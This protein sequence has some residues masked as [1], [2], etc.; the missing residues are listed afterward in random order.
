MRASKTQAVHLQ[1][2]TWKNVTVLALVLGCSGA[3]PAMVPK[4]QAEKTLHELKKKPPNAQKEPA[5]CGAH[6]LKGSKTSIS[7]SPRANED[8]ERLAV[9]L[10]GELTAPDKAYD[11]IV[12]DLGA[13]RAV[14][15]EPG[16]RGTFPYFATNGVILGLA[17]ETVKEVEAGTYKGL[18]CLNDWYGG[19]VRSTM[20]S[21]DM[22]F[23]VFDALYHPKV[24]ADAYASH[25]EVRLADANRMGGGGDDISLCNATLGGTHRYM[26]TRAWGDCP[27]GCINFEFKGYDVTPAGQVTPLETWQRNTS[28]GEYE[29]ADWVTPGCFKKRWSAPPEKNPK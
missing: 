4:A 15:P 3:K 6:I 7:K 29:A 1:I 18:D 23:I 11:R 2:L 20:G 17:P 22:I 27:S 16:A 14:Y 25:P 9:R 19:K 5:K 8:A 28:T 12:A 21:L 24:I 10:T 13:I 26:F